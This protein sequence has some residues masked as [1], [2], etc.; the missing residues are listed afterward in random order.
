[1]IIT[2]VQ[3]RSSNQFCHTERTLSVALRSDAPVSHCLQRGWRPT[4]SRCL[5][6]THVVS[7]G[8]SGPCKVRTPG[9]WAVENLTDPFKTHSLGVRPAA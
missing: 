3:T 4:G 8:A 2:T 7:G 6:L 9:N 5:V 1:M